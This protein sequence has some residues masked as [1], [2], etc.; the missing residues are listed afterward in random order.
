MP[1]FTFRTNNCS[2]YSGTKA[3]GEEVL[4]GQPNVYIWRLR[5]PFDQ[6]DNPRNY[7]TKLLRYKRLLE[8]T[9][10]ISQL[11]EFCAATFA[12]WEKRVPFGLYNVTNPGHVT[13][14]EVVDLI[15]AAGV[16]TK[17]FEF[18]KDEGEFMHLAAKTPRSNCI[19]DSSKLAS[20]GIRMTEV[21]EAVTRDL[22]RWVRSA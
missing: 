15:K 13:T 16:S 12:C 8:A 11:E 2:F 1:N 19:M 5:I 10:S 21:R 14:R 4:A 18:F 3:L 22:K 20:V 17:Q 9:N 6:H 7:L